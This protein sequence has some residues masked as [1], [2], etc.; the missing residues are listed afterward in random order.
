M[1]RK[2]LLYLLA[3]IVLVGC[4]LAGMFMSSMFALLGMGIMNL[5]LVILS[6]DELFVESPF[7]QTKLIVLKSSLTP[8][9]Q[10]GALFFM[11]GLLLA[12]ICG[13]MIFWI[14]FVDFDEKVHIEKI[15]KEDENEKRS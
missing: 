11:I 7:N 4:L 3:K 1:N 15:K 2:L 14:L 6:F 13:L 8:V 12:I 10:T 5:S 9:I